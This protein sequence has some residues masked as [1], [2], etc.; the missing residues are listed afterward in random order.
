[1]KS[2]EFLKVELEKIATDF[3][4]IHIK[5]NFNKDIQTHIVELLPLE[6]YYKNDKLIDTWMPLSF[7]FREKF[8]ME[9]I[10]FISSDSTLSIEASIF[11]FNVP[12]S[13][14]DLI[15]EFFEP[16]THQELNY[17]FPTT[18]PTGAIF[19]SHSIAGVLS[20]PEQHIIEDTDLDTFYQAAA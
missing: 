17:T 16:L 6:E 19:I 20:C 5:Y 12:V 13:D 11:E 4:Y 2:I 9:E 3:P 8:P 7:D 10:S 14:F 1:M 18:M 15:T